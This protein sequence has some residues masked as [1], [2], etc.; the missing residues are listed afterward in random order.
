MKSNRIFALIVFTFAFLLLFPNIKALDQ[1]G[2]E[3]MYIWKAAYYSERLIKT[4]F[5]K[6]TDP[7][8]DPGFDPKSFWAW[9]QPFGSHWIYAFA[10]GIS[11][12][13]P[14]ELPYS[15]TDFKLQGSET[16]IPPNTLFSARL[17]AIICAA[18]GLALL[19]LRFGWAGFISSIA[20][21]AIPFTG[22]NLSRAWAEGPLMLGFGLCAIS[23][24]TRWFPIT[25]GVAAAF[26]LTALAL[27]PLLA[28]TGSCGKEFHWRRYI[29]TLVP[30]FVVSLLTPVSWFFGGPLYLLIIFSL[31]IDTWLLQSKTM[32]TFGGI[33]FPDRYLW[34]FVLLALLLIAHFSQPMIKKIRTQP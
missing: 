17:A 22:E 8:L 5:S 13:Q 9:E 6:G 25:L 4:D 32:P 12:T 3:K 11:N 20:L 30:P 10:M 18:T 23:Y 34:P 31:R 14:P 28:I 21:L 16:N 24:K 2:D 26:K 27:F 1:H 33:F 19:T 29:S 7:Y 15:Y